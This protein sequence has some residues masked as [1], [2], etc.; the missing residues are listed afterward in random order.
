M[1]PERQPRG[2]GAAVRDPWSW[3]DL[4][5]IAC[6]AE[7]LGY[8]ALLMPEIGGRD[9]LAALTGLSG[10]ATSILLGT[11]VVP[12]DARSPQLTAMGGATV[13]ERS[14]GRLVLGLGTGPPVE[15]ALARLREL[16]IG[17][18]AAFEGRPA[19]VAG[20]PLRLSLVPSE[21]P[22]I[23]ISALGPRAVALAG[24]VA[25]GILLNWCSPERVAAAVESVR[26]SAESAA[27]DPSRIAIAVYVRANLAG[28]VEAADLALQAAAGEYASY[29]AYARQFASMGLGEAA[30]AGASAHAAGRPDQVPIALVNATCLRGDAS[31]ARTRLRAYEEAGAWLP[32]VYPV[33]DPAGPSERVT[34]TLRALAPAR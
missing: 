25:D 12:M 33:V 27:R 16:V 10:E 32:V 13:Q 22:P 30:A 4:S 24:E 23:W 29:P 14:G 19:A 8:R 1:Q 17:L 18:R 34:D 21:P 3:P 7:A 26:G 11:G 31:A 15:G 2:T 20:R 5:R 28:D 6:E 9:T